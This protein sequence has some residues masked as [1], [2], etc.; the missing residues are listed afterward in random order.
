MI[1]LLHKPRVLLLDSVLQV[2]PKSKQEEIIKIIKKLVKDGLTVI[3]FTNYLQESFLTDKI[4]LIDKFNILGEYSYSDIFSN[5][6][7][8]YEHNLEI[9]FMTD[10]SIKLKMY[11]L[12]DKEYINMKEMVDDLWP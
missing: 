4:I 5:D 11:N 2:F 8:F 10:L 3:S 1:A 9:P 7:D 12:V 6:K